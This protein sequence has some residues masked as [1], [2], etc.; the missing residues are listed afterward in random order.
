MRLKLTVIEKFPLKT[1]PEGLAAV[2]VRQ[3]T[4]EDAIQR[5]DMFSKTRRIFVENDQEQVIEQDF[6]PREVRAYEA[7][8]TLASVD[9]IFDQEDAPLF[10][11]KS[12]KDGD[13]VKSA[14]SF[15]EFK[16]AWGSLPIEVSDEI[17]KFI[18]K[19]NR[20]WDG[21]AEKE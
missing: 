9:G 7:Y 4:T 19:V 20:T 14:M 18:L 11:H 16:V 15:D 2:S 17:V 10:R 21:N 13:R 8:L 12:T 1:D 5:N 6:N 3:A